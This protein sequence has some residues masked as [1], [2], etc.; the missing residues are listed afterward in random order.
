MMRKSPVLAATAATLV[1]ACLVVSS[2][3]EARAHHG[4]YRH[5]AHAYGYAPW[6]YAPVYRR[7]LPYGT[8][9]GYRHYGRFDSLLN[10]D[11]QMVG[12]FD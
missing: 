5:Y 9:P 2:R 11:R 12:V 1:A 3:A 8:Y 4:L 10:P 7:A 6:G